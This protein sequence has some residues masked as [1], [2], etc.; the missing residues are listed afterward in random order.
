M[1]AEGKPKAQ[2]PRRLGRPA[3]AVSTGGKVAIWLTI[4]GM[5]GLLA[6]VGLL[7]A[8]SSRR[9]PAFPNPPDRTAAARPKPAPATGKAREP[10]D[11]EWIT[12]Y[13]PP[14]TTERSGHRTLR[15][16]I[17]AEYE[18]AKRRVELY[19]G[20][21]RWGD[22]IAALER[23]MDRY[24]DEE[25]RLRA[26]PEV[27]ELRR[28]A[29]RAFKARMAE[30]DKLAGE[31]RVADARKVL[32]GVTAFGIEDFTA[33]AKERVKQLVAREDAEAAAHYAQAIAA[34]D[35]TLPT[36]GFEAALAEVRKLK[37]DRPQYQELHARRVRRI[38]ALVAL[39]KQI[40]DAILDAKPRLDKRTLGVPG[41]PG[42]LT[43]ADAE[44]IHTITRQGEEKIA[45]ERL[46]PDASARLA[47]LAGNAKDPKHVLAVA[48]LLLEL[49]HL[50]RAREEL[51]RA[52]HLGA[53]TA[54]DEAD[55]ASRRAPPAKE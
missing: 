6:L 17:E 48:R 10:D 25:L 44:Y 45:W 12:L 3:P 53:D 8:R 22:A 7:V 47:L 28:Q 34:I 9:R 30:A 5:A 19:V 14:E 35:A 11:E 1:D 54:A 55:L 26:D 2:A 42:E 51:D 36:W 21:N 16:R 13:A 52:R 38:E 46:G 23:V 41:W 39:K 50:E 24:D 33:Q 49:G 31:G 37:F 29:N 18:A 40:I 4:L 20:Q 43:V 32:D 27:V 15:E